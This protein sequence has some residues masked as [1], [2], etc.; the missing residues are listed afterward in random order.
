MNRVCKLA[1][2]LVGLIVLLAPQARAAVIG[3]NV[4]AASLTAARI[5][6]L[7]E[8]QRAV[9]IA[10]LTRS[11]QQREIDRAAL[12]AERAALPAG[13]AIPAPPQ[14]GH[15]EKTMPLN[16]APSWYAG[17][18][19]RLVADNIV[20]FQTPAGGWGKNQPRDRPP[21]RLGQDYVADNNSPRAVV[22]DFDLAENPR[23]SYVGTID[24][25]ATITEIRFLAKVA[26]QLPDAS[27]RTYRA[28]ALKGVAYLLA[29][30]FPNGGW[31]QVWPLQGGYHD[32]L[33][34]NDNAVVEVAELLGELGL[35]QQEWAFVPAA[36]RAQALAA[37]QRAIGLL[38]AS[39][40][41]RHGRKTI[42]AQQYD[43]LSLAPVAARNYEP[44]SLC[45]GESV[46]ALLYLMRQAEPSPEI[47]QAVEAGMATLRALALADVQWLRGDETQGRRLLAKPGAGPLWARYYDAASLKPVFGDRDKT[48]HDDVNEIS[49]ERR[50]GYAWFGTWPLKALAAYEA[51]AARWLK[52]QTARP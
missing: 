21:R 33:T 3:V 44:A 43:A 37:E 49:M 15:A 38:L 7:P 11:T 8:G 52:P 18:A 42:W 31:P 16:Q 46:E 23:W 47:Q 6:T 4:P 40:I 24:N 39:Q 28:S 14:G 27:A 29:A 9:W 36:L 26:A 48:L 34:L 41:S 19:A 45:T 10:Y 20:S 50:N 51:W 17:A 22:G 25:D 12:A 32:A 35:G 5:D 1:V 30:Q 13:I 2:H